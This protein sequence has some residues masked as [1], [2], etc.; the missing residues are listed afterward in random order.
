MKTNI[1]P[2]QK[3]K[4][5]GFTLVEL[6]VVIAIIASLAGLSYG[7]IMRHLDS[8]ARSEAI[9]NGKNLHSALLGFMG[10]N[11]N[12]FPNDDTGEADSAEAC[13]QQLIDG[14][15]VGDEKYFWNKANGKADICSINQPDNDGT[16][17]ADE[18]AWGYTKNLDP[19][20]DGSAPILYDSCLSA[21][22]S[23][24]SFST[25]SWKGK[26]I[27]VRV[28]ASCK[29]LD[30]EYGT[31][32]PLTDTGGEKTGPITEKR[33]ATEEDIFASLPT[34]AEPLATTSGG[35]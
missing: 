8:A 16:L 34:Y 15:F 4:R 13:L 33:G 26:A 28:D 21:S 1:Q 11:D 12:A 17:D 2:T 31:G 5:Q 14:D 29:A 6:L 3:R 10:Q 24:G 25:L 30:I 27:V 23:A 20:S 22:P 32:K 9:T 18:N 35:S 7:P 19:G